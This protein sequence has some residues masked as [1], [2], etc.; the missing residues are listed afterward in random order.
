M[1]VDKVHAWIIGKQETVC[2]LKGFRET[3]NVSRYT[4][5]AVNCDKCLELLYSYGFDEHKHHLSAKEMVSKAQSV[6]EVVHNPIT[7]L[8]SRVK[9][10]NDEE[11][12]IDDNFLKEYFAVKN[13][14]S[15][16]VIEEIIEKKEEIKVNPKPPVKRNTS[17][18]KK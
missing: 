8:L 2:G 18:K 9:K 6:P 5:M 12:E 3:A 4:S 13:K 11:S 1:T 14:I 15:N 16:E 10:H 7:D 17:H